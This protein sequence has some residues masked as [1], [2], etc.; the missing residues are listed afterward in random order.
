[1]S[2]SDVIELDGKFYYCNSFG[3]KRINLK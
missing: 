3:F 2:M 1:L